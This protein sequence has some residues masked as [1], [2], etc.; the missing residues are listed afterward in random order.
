MWA[1]WIPCRMA[2]MG[3]KS[4]SSLARRPLT[5]CLLLHMLYW[6]FFWNE[7]RA[8]ISSVL[9]W[10]SGS[11][12]CQCTR[13]DPWSSKQECSSLIKSGV[14]QTFLCLFYVC[15]VIQDSSF[16]CFSLFLR[17]LV[18]FPELNYQLKI[19]VCIDKWVCIKAMRLVWFSSPRLHLIWRNLF[20]LSG[21]R[22]TSLQSEGENS[23]A[24]FKQLYLE[25]ASTRHL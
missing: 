5:L 16:C 14:M 20:Q 4:S 19:K 22:E 8:S 10:W 25:K 12:V 24:I 1:V 7:R 15:A 18:K 2:Q 23:H 3:W 13:T 17:L 11:R 21:S 6:C 9:S